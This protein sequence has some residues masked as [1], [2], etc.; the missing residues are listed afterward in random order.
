MDFKI[1]NDVYDKFKLILTLYFKDNK[2]N[3][4]KLTATKLFIKH[5]W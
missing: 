2:E 1:L 3:I 4:W 5:D